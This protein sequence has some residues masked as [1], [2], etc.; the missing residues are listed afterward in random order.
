MGFEIAQELMKHLDS[1]YEEYIQK[2]IEYLAT[3]AKLSKLETSNSQRAILCLHT[4]A[5]FITKKTFGEKAKIFHPKRNE[6]IKHYYLR[7]KK[8]QKIQ[9]HEEST[10]IS[11]INDE[12]SG[13]ISSDVLKY[14]TSNSNLNE[15][16]IISEKKNPIEHISNRLSDKTPSED[17]NDCYFD[18]NSSQFGYIKLICTKLKQLFLH[19]ELPIR[20]MY[21]FFILF[22]IIYTMSLYI[23]DKRSYLF[24]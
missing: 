6:V 11:K 3:I 24:T 1:L 16:R 17:S 13:T 2:L 21:I 19:K 9:K 18:V 23:N 7:H 12:T 8:N 10:E 14:E 20:K 15:Q 5:T 4:I 22:Y